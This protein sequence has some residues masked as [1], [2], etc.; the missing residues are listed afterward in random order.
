[1]SLNDV[2]SEPRRRSEGAFE[3]D[4]RAIAGGFEAGPAQGLGRDISCEPVSALRDDGQAD[5]IDGNAVAR[6][7]A[8]QDGGGGHLHPRTVGDGRDFFQ[9]SEFFDNSS[10]HIATFTIQIQKDQFTFD[11]TAP[12]ILTTTS[13][14]DKPEES[15]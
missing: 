9:S 7:G 8:L 3:V 5:S 4:A 2:T 13:S 12:R 11:D 15:I 10:K 6:P 14:I 1:M